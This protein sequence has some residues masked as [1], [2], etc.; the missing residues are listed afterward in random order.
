MR[1]NVQAF[2]GSNEDNLDCA[3]KF[4]SVTAQMQG[5]RLSP[6]LHLKREIHT[7]AGAT[8]SSQSVTRS[9]RTALALYQVLCG[10]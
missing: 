9:V 10:S 5:K 2:C 3:R 4:W 6:D 8:L 1:G 7:I